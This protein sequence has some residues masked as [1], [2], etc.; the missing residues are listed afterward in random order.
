MTAQYGPQDDPRTIED[1]V[2]VALA[3]GDDEI[4]WDAVV[5]LQWR[6]SRDVLQCAKKLSQS[7]C[8]T[9]RRLAAQLLGQ[10]GLP[11]RTFPEESAATLIRMLEGENDEDVQKAILIAFSHLYDVQVIPMAVRFSTH[12][13]FEIRLAVTMAVMGLKVPEA[14]QL[15]IRLSHDSDSSVRDWATFGIGTLSDVDTPMVR[16]ALAERL[17]DDSQ[18]VRCEALVGLAR[19]GD[20][21]VIESLKTEL[22]GECV[23]TLAVEAAEW[24]GA[25]E[26]RPFLLQ[27]RDWWDVDTELLERAIAKST[28]L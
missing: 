7:E 6:G 26:L 17:K 4:A 13:N 19:R 28:E 10:L 9:E 14:I 5:A 1:L 11:D 18:V 16:L 25:S 15:L 27:L 3:H 12:W 21:Q 20:H 2:A 22:A 24:I 8:F 23:D